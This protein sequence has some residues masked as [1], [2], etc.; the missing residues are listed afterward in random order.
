MLKS[1]LLKSLLL[2]SLLLK[3]LLVEVVFYTVLERTV[4]VLSYKHLS[5][6]FASV[7]AL[8]DLSG[9]FHLCLLFFLSSSSALCPCNTLI[10]HNNF[11]CFIFPPKALSPS[12]SHSL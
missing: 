7:S 12:S 10:S 1:L 2:E 3:S 11:I 9:F 4:L 8:H 6:F 5:L